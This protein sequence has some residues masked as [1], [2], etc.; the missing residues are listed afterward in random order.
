MAQ[1]SE[2]MAAPTFSA[3]RQRRLHEV[4]V[5]FAPR[6]VEVMG[7]ALLVAGVFLVLGV[8]AA[9]LTT[10][11]ALVAVGFALGGAD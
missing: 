9:L 7:A 5:A 6:I 11:I 10:G 4:L 8:G 2:A 3:E 1:G